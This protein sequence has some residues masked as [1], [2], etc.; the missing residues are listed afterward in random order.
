[1][2]VDALSPFGRGASAPLAGRTILQIVPPIDAGGDERAALAVTAALAEA[3]ARPLIATDS[4]ELAGELQAVGGLH[5]RYPAATKNPL[6]MTLNLRRLQRIVADERVDL[7]HTRS[8]WAAW[9]AARVCRKSRRPLITAIAGDGGAAPRTPFEG[10][11]AQGE[12]VIAPSEFAARR[13]A[14]VFPSVRARLRIV[15]PGIDLSRL[16][17]EQVTRQRVAETRAAWGAAPD[18]RVVLMPAKLT[19]GRGHGTLIEA[20][21]II[22]AH[23]LDDLRFVLAGDAAK[24]AFARELDQIA[25]A[26]GVRSMFVRV[27]AAADLPAAIVAAA[28]VALPATEV[29]GVTR[30]AIE[31]AALGGLIV[32]SDIGPARE[33]IA[34]PPY[35]EADARA[36]WLTPPG[37]AAALAQ[38]I[39]TA[40]SIGASGRAAIQRRARARAAAAFSLQRMTH[41]TLGVYAEA[42]GG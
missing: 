7:V 19:P 5:V 35:D 29:E 15:R 20:A 2:S 23:G 32:I 40:L 24:P 12:L 13:A 14:A 28:L 25:A 11:M 18:E 38:A 26:R 30:T 10:A 37:D 41:D 9:A 6:A 3:G 1:V 17:P 8:R 27:G 4:D 16:Q 31:A 39:E 34:A 42:L 21:A 22:K 36:G 33:I